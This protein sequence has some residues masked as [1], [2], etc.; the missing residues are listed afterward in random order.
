MPVNLSPPGLF[1]MKRTLFSSLFV[2]VVTLGLPVQGWT[3]VCVLPAIQV[4]ANASVAAGGT[5]NLQVSLGI[6]AP[7]DGV[8]L[9]FTSSNPSVA[10]VSPTNI[11]ISAGQT[12]PFLPIVVTGAGAGTATITASAA[13]FTA[14]STVVTVGNPS[15]GQI[16]LPSPT[17][18]NLGAGVP[19]AVTLA[20]PAPAGGLIVTLVVSNPLVVGLVE[21]SVQFSAGSTTPTRTPI[22]YG[23]SV[24]SGTVTASA[25]GLTSAVAVVTIV[26]PANVSVTWG[27]ACVVSTTIYNVTGHFQGI[28]Y[29]LHSPQPMT[30]N[31][32]LFFNSSC[33]PKD[34]TDNMND[35]GSLT[36][37]G[38]GIQG[39]SHHPDDFP[40]SAVYWFGPRTSDG[41][42]Y[43]GSPCSGCVTYTANTP[44][45]L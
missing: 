1:V 41:K 19:F 14:A 12:T 16:Q 39:F 38:N 17:T 9:A 11:S 34:G 2:S 5:A 21:T 15:S 13:G 42:C 45:C 29:S 7:A 24:G 36:N 35:F 27:A 37:P 40:T 28:P 44:G 23:S 20:N 43:P 3:Q 25:P 33:D 10:T 8:S 30:L 6:A 22:V 4:P 18:V 32:T 26:A 31:A